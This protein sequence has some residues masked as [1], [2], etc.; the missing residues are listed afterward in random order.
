VI[1]ACNGT[2]PDLDQDGTCDDADPDDDG[3]GHADDVD[4]GP[5]A[6]E[7]HPGATEQPDDGI[8]QDCSG[9]DTVTCFVDDDGDG[10]GTPITVRG[11]GSCST[12]GISAQSGDCDDSASAV[13]P[14]AGEIANDGVDQDCDGLD[15]VVC[16]VDGD[17][18]GFGDAEQITPQDPC[19]LR[20]S[21]RVPRFRCSGGARSFSW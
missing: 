3:D 21:C 18:D 4:C 9:L 7:I 15:S 19:T 16:H 13:F 8:D 20:A 17:G 12:A 14:G 10:F 1:T 6:P 11:E 5:R 2:E